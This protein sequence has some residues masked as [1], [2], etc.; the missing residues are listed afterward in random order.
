MSMSWQDLANLIAEM[1]PEDAARPAQVQDDGSGEMLE[2]NSLEFPDD[3][4]EAY[5]ITEG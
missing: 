4:Q 2:I 5:M 1:G 3:D